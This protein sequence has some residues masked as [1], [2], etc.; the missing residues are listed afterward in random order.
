M[1]KNK[2]IKMDNLESKLGK[3]GL[4]SKEDD[5]EEKNISNERFANGLSLRKRKINLILSKQR[6]FDKFK[7]EGD[8]DYQ[9]KLEQIKIPDEIKT[10]KFD[11]LD[12][13]V[14]D[15]KTYLTSENKEYNKFA[16]YCLRIQTTS[17]DGSN[18]KNLL[19]EL[20]Q[21]KDLTSDILNLI[22][23]Y[24]DDRLIIYEGLWV[25]INVLYYQEENN[26]DLQL[27]LSNE[28]CT[29]LYIKILD[30]K[31]NSLRSN[32]YWLLSNLLSN[33]NNTAS[34]QIIFHLYMSSLFRVY[35]YKDLDNQYSKLTENDLTNLLNLISR[36]SDFINE[37]F[38]LLRKNNIQKF[39]D[40]NSNV[41]YETIKENNDYLFYHSMVIF[42]DNVEN[43]KFT[44]YCIFGLSRLTNFLDDSR[45]FNEFFKSG[46]VRKI[47]KEQIKI[48]EDII[49][50][51]IQI[52][53]NYLSSVPDYYLDPIILEEIIYYYSKIL[54]T[55]PN[56]KYI[57]RD[58]F[59]GVGN[60]LAGDSN[61]YGDLLAKTGI[62]ENG[63]NTIHTE[64]KLDIVLEA[65]T[66]L[67]VFFDV[68]NIEAIIK[69]INLDYMKNLIL[70]LKYIHGKCLTGLAFSNDEIMERLL[71]CIG[72][73]IELGKLYKMENAGNKFVI[74]FENNGGYE[75]VDTMLTAGNFSPNTIEKAEAILK[76]KSENSLF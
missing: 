46:I 30:K 62:I 34:N 66:M 63:L 37:T 17:N 10:K 57:K 14:K 28:Q 69:N 26:Y 70:C 74:D 23:K 72:F 7:F 11:D 75:L 6:G 29:N 38:I 71:N 41:N 47:V 22:Q 18:N 35:I 61:N 4:L 12:A 51:A 43:P 65:L 64:V 3:K 59:W 56:Q 21:K 31:D 5:D 9:L 19:C 15:M 73:L 39:I 24:L 27:Y 20:L 53:G 13:F 58:I 67:A 54:K 32:V 44:D 25:L 52:I 16:L 49:T 42:I 76:S 55:Y 40:Y 2:L 45:A 1:V 68:N 33:V 8:R 48:S 50:Y 36:L 60:I